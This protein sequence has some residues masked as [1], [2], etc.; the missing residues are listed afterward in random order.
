MKQN[1]VHSQVSNSNDTILQNDPISGAEQFRQSE[2]SNQSEPESDTEFDIDPNELEDNL[3]SDSDLKSLLLDIRKDV[4]QI[5]HKFDNMKKSIKDLKQSNKIL[6]RQ[7]EGL[8]E[9]VANL[10][11]QVQNL[12]QIAYRNSE[13]NEK[14]ESQSRRSNLIIYGISGDK[15][16]SWETSEDKFRH[17]I[18]TELGISEHRMPTERV[19]RLR[20]KSTPAPII[21]KFSFFKDREKVL[22][23]YREK[24][25]SEREA[26]AA[27]DTSAADGQNGDGT[28]ETTQ[29]VHVGEDFPARVRKVRKLLYPFQKKCI[30]EEKNAY[31][32]YD[33]LIIDDEVYV[34][35][36]EKKVPVLSTK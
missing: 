19:H 2:N 4:K 10:K 34:Y 11:I 20:S 26:G 1:Q 7:N 16:E 35:D 9:T 5:N 30:S 17:Y 31:I 29:S 22:K 24:R 15:D 18:E 3:E 25:K 12:E 14:L 28:S 13:A 6:Q 33:K 27:A 21:A 36:Y 32:K 23:A 8:T